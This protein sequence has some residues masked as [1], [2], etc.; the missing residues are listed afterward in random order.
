VSAVELDEDGAGV[1]PG[2]D[3]VAPSAL[4]GE[5]AWRQYLARQLLDRARAEGVRLIG[6]GGLLAGVTKAVL[7]T[8]LQAEMTEHLGY[9]H[10]DHP[11]ADLGLQNKRNGTTSKTVHTGVG[12]VEIDVPRDRDGSFEPVVVAKHARRVNGFD[13]AIISLYAKGLTT[14]EIQDHME[15]VYGADVSRD[16]I[17]KVT[18]AVND[19]L[20]AWRNRP[21]D[22]VYPVLFV[23]AIVVK[24]RD[25]Q[26]TNRP[27][28]VVV[29]VN[30]EGQR[31]VLGLWIGTGGE[32]A[33]QWHAY[34]TELRN[35]GVAD[36]FIVCSDGLKG[37][38]E[39]IET[40]W[41]MATH[42]QCVVHLVRAS[43]RY[44]ARKDWQKLTPAIRAMYTAST[45]D[46]AQERFE[47]FAEAWGTKYPA[48]IK[49][50]R[51]TWE[52][53]T[54]FLAYD[55]DVRRVVYTT[56][57]IES[58]NARF[59]QATRRRGHFPTE[60]AALKVL[61]LVIRDKTNRGGDIIARVPGWRQALNAFALSY[62]D[63]VT[64]N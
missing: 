42:Q 23:D 54:P 49:M 8:A 19:E 9:E 62:G 36:A 56:N 39:A 2:T 58:L 63:R 10:G 37:I 52:R 4:F 25:G 61:Y 24:I 29:G 7:E 3:L 22:R 60:Q 32:G 41:Q 59:R 46:E 11:A 43:L 1:V 33:K 55:V 12:P 6:P 64:N 15:D 44:S 34:L 47:E 31:D 21:L 40:V 17:S 51:E 13:E 45:V 16:F 48:M 53:F 30:L 26:V 38:G 27:V 50:W 57:M 28:Y 35:R 18:D 20:V 5:D 14:G